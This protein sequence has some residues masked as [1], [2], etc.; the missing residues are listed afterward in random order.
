MTLVP[1]APDGAE[2]NPALVYIGS[3]K[4]QESK[5]TVRAR[6]NK[7]AR[8]FR[9]G[10]TAATFPWHEL[11]YEDVQRLRGY[12][13][14]ACSYKTANMCLCFLRKTLR[15]AWRLGLLDAEELARVTDVES[16]RGESPPTGRALELEEVR[17]LLDAAAKDERRWRA[18]RDA[19]L[20]T[21]LYCAGIRRAEASG[22]QATDIE[23]AEGRYWL[24]VL[25][26]GNKTR[27]VPL[28]RDARA[29]VDAWLDVRGRT[30]GPLFPAR[31]RQG[32]QLHGKPM[33]E[34]TVGRIVNRLVKRA[35]LGHI[36]P[37]FFRYTFISTLLDESGDVSAIQKL[38]GHADVSMTLRYDRRA[39]RA[40]VRAVDKLP[41]PFGGE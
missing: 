33:S 28:P 14:E 15:V 40:R 32:Q 39:E 23:D 27:R 26:K 22:L 10:A 25:G 30:A 11:R 19:A 36:T 41:L 2:L 5:R 34:N 6:L 7:V 3:M 20:V 18:K 35:S 8:F 13:A 1:V 31:S 29:V 12:L 24:R 16:I 17:A 9:E 38:A 21:I 4:S 37:H